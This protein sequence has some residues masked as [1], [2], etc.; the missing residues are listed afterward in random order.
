MSPGI[1][2][3]LPFSS[4]G[5]TFVLLQTGAKEWYRQIELFSFFEDFLKLTSSSFFCIMSP[6]SILGPGYLDNP[7][8]LPAG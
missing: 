6:A 8:L 5:I 1:C 7:P 3:L 2:L 4:F